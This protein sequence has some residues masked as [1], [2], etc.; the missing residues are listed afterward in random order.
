[1]SLLKISD[2][3]LRKSD[4]GRVRYRCDVGCCF[5]FLISRDI[6]AQDFKIKT[7]KTNHNCA[8]A[9]KNRR[10]IPQVLPYYFKIKVQNNSK[11]KVKDMRVDLENRFSLNI[12]YSRLKRDRSR[13]IRG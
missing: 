13:E 2:L 7:L 4:I 9:Y 6:R 1:M 3:E 5:V 11:Y 8:P 12:S 10:V